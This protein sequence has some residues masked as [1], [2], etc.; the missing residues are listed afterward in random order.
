MEEP[1]TLEEV[2]RLFRETDKKLDRLEAQVDRTSRSVDAI[3]DRW[4]RFVENMVAPAAQ[5]LFYERGIPVHAVSHRVRGRRN[6][7]SMEIDLLVTNDD[8][9]VLIEVKSNLRQADV[10]D[11]LERL[12]R[13]KTIF[14]R[15]ADARVMGAVAGVEVADEV[16]LY[17]YRKGLFVLV[18]SGETMAIAN[19]DRFVPAEW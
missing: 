15:Y 16:A 8:R 19:D 7:Q 4:G 6:G 13:F 18:Q 2:W 12:Q 14:P 5:R 11:H 10:D 17:A 3:T 1:V 9:A